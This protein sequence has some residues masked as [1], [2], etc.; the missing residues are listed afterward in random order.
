MKSK[1][2]W[3]IYS[4]MGVHERKTKNNGTSGSGR[5]LEVAKYVH[6]YG[7]QGSEGAAV[8]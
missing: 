2:V 7:W 8:R 6:K 4:C 3:E 1:Y 5:H